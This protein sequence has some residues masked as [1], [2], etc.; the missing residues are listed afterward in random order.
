MT[1]WPLGW[2]PTVE[3]GMLSVKGELCEQEEN[4]FADQGPV[5]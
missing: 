2:L 1:D 5:A 4:V 3:L